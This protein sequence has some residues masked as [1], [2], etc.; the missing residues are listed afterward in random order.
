MRIIACLL[1]AL[2]AVGSA[3]AFAKQDGFSRSVYYTKKFR[4]EQR[5]NHPKK[6]AN[7]LK[8]DLKKTPRDESSYS[9]DAE[10][11]TKK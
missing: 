6:S 3:S 8:T 4:Q 10:Q 11:K 2:L 5:N 1:V 7:E 9:L